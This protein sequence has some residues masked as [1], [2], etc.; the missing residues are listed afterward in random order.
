MN[1]DPQSSPSVPFDELRRVVRLMKENDL[2][3]FQFEREGFRLK[4]RRGAEPGAV[5]APATAAPAAATPGVAPPVPVAQPAEGEDVPSPMVGTFYRTASPNDP[6]F[7]NPGDTVTLGQTL[8]IIEAMKVMNEI[9]AERGGLV[10]AVLAED[11]APVQFGQVLM[12]IK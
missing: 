6:P 7:V 9:K 4:L 5:A 1:K 8:C 10:T 12:R 3:F 11:G 2:S